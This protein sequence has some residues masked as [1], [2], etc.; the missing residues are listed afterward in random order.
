MKMIDRMNRVL[1]LIAA[2]LNLRKDAAMIT[3]PI[4]LLYNHLAEMNCSTEVYV[5]LLPGISAPF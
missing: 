5:Y 4:P 2:T 1:V 3:R